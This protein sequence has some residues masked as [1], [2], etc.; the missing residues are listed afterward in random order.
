MDKARRNTLTLIED[1]NINYSTTLHLRFLWNFCLLRGRIFLF[2][3]RICL[4]SRNWLIT[5]I[6]WN[7]AKSCSIFEDEAK[8]NSDVIRVKNSKENK[9][10]IYSYKY[11]IVENSVLKSKINERRNFGWISLRDCLLYKG[12]EMFF[13]DCCTVTW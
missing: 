7:R 9:N 4:L 11:N 5:D 13:R 12:F 10:S 1:I 8:D 6:S 3:F 2:R